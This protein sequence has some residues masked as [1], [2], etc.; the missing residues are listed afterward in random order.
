MSFR[1]VLLL[2]MLISTNTV[3]LARDSWVFHVENRSSVAVKNFRTQENGKWSGNWIKGDIIR[4]GEKF[5]MD[6]GSSHGDCTVRT[7]ITFTDGTYFDYDV[8]YCEVNVIVIR[9]QKLTFE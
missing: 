2:L 5:E 4:S 1:L 7:Q 9:E 6:F 8:D 3:S